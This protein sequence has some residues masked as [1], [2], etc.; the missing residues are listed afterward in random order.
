MGWDEAGTWRF[1]VEDPFVCWGHGSV[2]EVCPSGPR[3]RTTDRASCAPNPGVWVSTYTSAHIYY[4]IRTRGLSVL[5]TRVNYSTSR[6]FR[7]DRE[8]KLLRKSGL[9]FSRLLVRRLGARAL[10]LEAETVLA[11][12]RCPRGGRVGGRGRGGRGGPVGDEKVRGLRWTSI[13]AGLTGGSGT[14]CVPALAIAALAG[15]Y[16]RCV[17]ASIRA[18]FVLPEESEEGRSGRGLC[19][20]SSSREGRRGV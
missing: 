12:A 6:A 5:T 8:A 20:G 9:S 18:E 3:C 17:C 7:S 14:R 10:A 4:T 13:S 1:E 2:P 11:R 16:M 15:G 19:S